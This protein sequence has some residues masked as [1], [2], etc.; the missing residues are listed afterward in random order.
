MADQKGV[1][2][3]ELDTGSVRQQISQVSGALGGLTRVLESVKTAVTGA[4]VFGGLWDLLQGS[5]ELEDQFLSLRLAVG[6]LKKALVEALIPI[7]QA[8]LPV[9]TQAVHTATRLIRYLGEIIKALFGSGEKS[10]PL[11]ENMEEASQAAKELKR[12]L[13]GFDQLQRLDADTGIV[14]QIGGIKDALEEQSESLDLWQNLLISK[15]KA[16][17]EPL[18]DIDFSSAKAAFGELYDALAPFTRVLFSGLEWAWENLLVP[19]T[20]WTIE[21]VLPAFL[22]LLAVT[23][24]ILAAA[25]EAAKPLLSWLWDH[26]LKPIAQWTGGVIVSVLKALTERLRGV[27]DWIDENEEAVAAITVTL[28]AFMAV[29]AVSQITQ[30]LTQAQRLPG[31]FSNIQGAIALV[32]AAMALLG[33]SAEDAFVGIRSAL[34]GVSGWIST[35]FTAPIVNGV[36]ASINGVIAFFNSLLQSVAAGMN[37]MTAAMNKL[38]F[39]IPQW[40]PE[41]GGKSFG[42]S[43]PAIKAPQI[44]YLAQGAVLPANQPFLAVVGDQKHG[45]NVEA[46]LSTIQEAVALVMNARAS[47]NQAGQEMILSILQQ[48]LEAILGIRIGDAV[49]A[50][51]A[52]RYQQKMA[53]VRGG[54]L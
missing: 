18:N 33:P 11:S 1:L 6:K 10:Q 52:Q 22:E 27:S 38:S 34:N 26:F 37:T 13:A 7:A 49:I 29:W 35:Y 47:E 41:V 21:N 48:I 14:S 5:E 20:K 19:L 51:A 46:P 12:S 4:F 54:S 28:G 3:I 24:G 36:K 25:I 30:W 44:P 16:L 43:L 15:I 8:I 2:R 9:I 50:Q 53:V 40:V 42:F 31:L 23:L 39:K 45:T 32:I 17:L